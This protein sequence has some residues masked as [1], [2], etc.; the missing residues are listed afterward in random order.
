MAT[1][2]WASLLGGL[3]LAG[4]GLAALAASGPGEAPAVPT[5][6]PVTAAPA[7]APA[8]VPVTTPAADL[9]AAVEAVLAGNGPLELID[10]SAYGIPA[11][12][13][14]VLAERGVVL[15]VTVDPSAAPIAG[16]GQ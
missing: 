13:A 6:P 12:V 5:S 10:P 15:T 4:A 1:K 14:R 8:P 2:E 9:P 16:K 7:P 3:V 11:E